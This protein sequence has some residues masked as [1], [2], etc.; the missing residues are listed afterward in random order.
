MSVSLGAMILRTVPPEHVVGQATALAPLVDELWVVEDLPFAGG[1]SQ[2]TAI[3]EA[4]KELADPPVI[5]HGIAPAPFRNP[6]ALAMEWA[7]LARAYPGR[8]HGGIGHGV[9]AWMEQIGAKPASTLMLLSETLLATRQLLAGETVN[10]AGR[11][12][13]L[14]N[15]TLEFP[16]A[17]VPPVSAGVTG[18]KSLRLAGQFADGTILSEGKG[19]D[20]VVAGRELIEQGRADAD[21]AG[22]AHVGD[23]RMT[24]FVG[25]YCGDPTLLPPPPED[26]PTGWDAVGADPDQV[27]G[28]LQSL[29]DVGVD[30]IVLVPFGDDVVGQIELAATEIAPRLAT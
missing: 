27:A 30:S 4:T 8:F 1:I 28:R 24:V 20:D 11:Y 10:E 29:V 13:Q 25:Y 22:L 15:V 17:S 16:P 7:T 3:L 23:H 14:E 18:P 26:L 12:V 6:A 21:A 5:G 9:P 19:P 2:A